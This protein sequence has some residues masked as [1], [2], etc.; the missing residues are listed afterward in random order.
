MGRHIK[1]CDPVSSTMISLGLGHKPMEVGEPGVPPIAP[2]VTDAILAEPGKRILVL[3]L[4][5]RAIEFV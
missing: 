2:A 1:Q 4:M 5:D 3:P